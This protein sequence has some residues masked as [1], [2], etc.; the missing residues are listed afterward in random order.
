RDDNVRALDPEVLERLAE[1]SLRQA[2]RID[3]RRVDQIDAG[4]E[5]A[6]DDGI[7]VL[8]PEI[9]EGAVE[10]VVPAEGHRAQ[11]DFGNE[12]AGIADPI[13]FH[14]CC[15]TALTSQPKIPTGSV[16]GDGQSS[17]EIGSPGRDGE[18]MSRKWPSCSAASACARRAS[19][20]YIL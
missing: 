20:A 9:A 2:V 14:G 6:R 3:V 11:A 7:D 13:V 16:P 19:P 12:Q 15:S 10:G 4:L 17:T 18:S 1:Q 5:R 8:L